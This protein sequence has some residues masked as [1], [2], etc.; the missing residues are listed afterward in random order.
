MPSDWLSMDD[1]RVPKARVEAQR[2]VVQCQAWQCCLNCHHWGD[3]DRS[4][5]DRPPGCNKWLTYPPA[6]VITVG[7]ENWLGLIP[8]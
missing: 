1:E 8:F 3:N 2:L 5:P 4:Q 6:E 7:C